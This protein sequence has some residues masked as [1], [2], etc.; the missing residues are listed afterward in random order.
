MF[1]YSR[2][3]LSTFRVLCYTLESGT[4]RVNEQNEALIQHT[5]NQELEDRECKAGY[6]IYILYQSM[7]RYEPEQRYPTL[8]V[9]LLVKMINEEMSS[10]FHIAQVVTPLRL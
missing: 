6:I 10:T 4:L 5:I 9:S 3:S 8:F 7:M 2:N 1:D